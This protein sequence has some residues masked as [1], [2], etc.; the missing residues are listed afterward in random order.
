MK[1]CFIVVSFL[2]FI[3]CLAAKSFG[4]SLVIT[5]NPAP[6]VLHL[7]A[8]GN[9]NLQVSDV[10]T[11]TGQYNSVSLTPS[12]FTCNDIGQQI[13]IVNAANSSA[14]PSP[15]NYPYGI[16]CDAAGNI[17]VAD[18]GN[19]QIKKIT[20]GGLVSVFAGTG[21][22]GAN[23]GAG[24]TATFNRP[25]GITMDKQGNIYVADA[26]N[27]LVRK[28]TPLAQVSTVAGSGAKGAVNGAGMTASFN[29]P[30]GVVVDAAGDVFVVDSDNNLVRKIAPDGTVST[31][32]GNGQFSSLD[33]NGVAAGFYNPHGIA[34]DASGNLFITDGNNR[35]RRISPNADVTTFAGNTSGNVDGAGPAASF[36]FSIGITIDAL[37]NVYIADTGNNEIRKA[38][39]G[40]FVTTIA[41]NGSIG[42][43]DGNGRNA[44]FNA[45]IGI[46]LDPAGNL[47]VTD[48]ADNKI[49]KIT[50]AGAVTTLVLGGGGTV[51]ESASLPVSVTVESQPVITSTY[52][53]ITISA[54]PG[55]YPVLPD[56]RSKATATDN[57][58]A[59][60]VIFSQSP[61]PGTP[62][63]VGSP[64]VVSLTATDESSATANISFTA[65]VAFAGG[66]MVS[67]DQNPVILAGTS[68]QLSPRIGSDIAR[69][70]WSPA[71]GLGDPFVRDP[72]VS[73]AVTTT[74]TLTVTSAAGCTG[75]AQVTVTVLEGLSIPNAFTPN[76]DGI[77]DFWDIGH[78][79]EY[80]SCTVDVFSRAGKL[81]FHS[82]GYGKPWAGTY[83]GSAL[84]AGAYYYVIDL[85]DGQKKLSGQVTII[86]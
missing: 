18:S 31:F 56:Y 66:P 54:Y 2:T 1:R 63:T 41:G 27:N 36:Y 46:A 68:V 53:D 40:A 28:I 44:L 20:P 78:L 3:I 67:F 72:M 86:K 14:G 16:V 74:Y 70:S 52:N 10:A 65:N 69:Y 30:A 82:L 21:A 25:W 84:P 12:T 47:Y 60:Q 32:A 29:N 58:A 83:N 24:S 15:L 81:V 4:Q 42:S 39:A 64:Q 35:I 26:G 55:C 34:I 79:V 13:V 73:P 45:P 62:L 75:S 9:Y 51:I 6:I 49:R 19:N 17:Y 57:C 23:N 50:P 43:A 80:P 85:N 71:T 61:A 59:Q 5:P 38:T 76:G 7:D 48:A 11:I 22:L 8:T 37:G 33:G 77:N